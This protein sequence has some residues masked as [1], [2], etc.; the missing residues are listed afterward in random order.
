VDAADDRGMKSEGKSSPAP[1][2]YPDNAVLT[3]RE[4]AAGLQIGERTAER[5]GLPALH[6]G[7]QTRRYVWRAVVAHLEGQ[8]P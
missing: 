4:V 5:L 3:L 7:K 2:C 1:V 8:S 6:L